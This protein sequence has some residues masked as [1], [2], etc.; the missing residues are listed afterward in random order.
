MIDNFLDDD[1]IKDSIQKI[2]FMLS[3]PYF[4]SESLFKSLKV[5]IGR[6]PINKELVPIDLFLKI[7]KVK[8][9]RMGNRKIEYRYF[10]KDQTSL[11]IIILKRK[12]GFTITSHIDIGIHGHAQYTSLSSTIL[13]ELSLVLI[14]T[15]PQLKRV[16][17]IHENNITLIDEVNKKITLE[18]EIIKLFKNKF[19]SITLKLAKSSLKPPI[20]KHNLIEKITPIIGKYLNTKD[21]LVSNILSDIIKTYFKKIVERIF[22]IQKNIKKR[23]QRLKNQ[24]IEVEPFEWRQSKENIPVTV[25]NFIKKKTRFGNKKQTIKGNML[26][27]NLIKKGIV[28]LTFIITE[29]DVIVNGYKAKDIIL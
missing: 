3:K 20:T 24:K 5:E 22:L 12:Y 19:D 2:S 9:I 29:N 7:C 16:G 21:P 10:F 23:K 26:P 11:H 4:L 15:N 13:T 28:E 25:K 8:K 18:E 27:K 6:Y 14:K 1:D 17:S